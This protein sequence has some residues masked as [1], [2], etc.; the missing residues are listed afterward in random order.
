MFFFYEITRF[1]CV[2]SK[3]A[4]E[5]KW[6]KICTSMC[7]PILRTIMKLDA[8]GGPQLPMG[9]LT[10]RDPADFHFSIF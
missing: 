3:N 2:K 4:H 5:Q 8:P 9:P 7:M 6:F 10:T 1:L